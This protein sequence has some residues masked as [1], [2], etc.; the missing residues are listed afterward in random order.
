MLAAAQTSSS[1][2]GTARRISDVRPPLLEA[3]VLGAATARLE[4]L[5]AAHGVPESHGAGHA[6]RVLA[7]TRLALEAAGAQ[8]S[9]SARLALLLA[10]LLHD[11]DDR[12]YFGKSGN[13]ETI[14]AEVLDG[15]PEGREVAATAL[16]AISYV[17]ASANGNSVSAA[18]RADPLL[19]YPRHAD[20]LEAIGEVGVV[21]CWQYSREIGRALY[22]ADTPC[23]ASDA[24]VFQIAA[25]E[26]FAAYQARG[27]SA[28][29]IDHFFDK[30]LHLAAP[31]VQ[32]SNLYISAL[33]INRTSPLLEVCLA[34]R[35]E[36][37]EERLALARTRVEAGVERAA[38]PGHRKTDAASDHFCHQPR[39]RP[40]VRLA[41]VPPRR[42]TGTHRRWRAAE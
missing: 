40:A 37:L 18:A 10:A 41:I 11:S 17:S 34:S 42:S 38:R 14:L 2:E 20:R 21:R 4:D 23:P 12:K 8:P 15:H 35:P 31:L 16:E 28:S 32:H 7:H 3:S 5:F 29:M 30:L 26:R 1:P 22:T 25:P 24:Q 13:A 6:Q 27:T 33:G 39:A 19:L 36:G 9:R